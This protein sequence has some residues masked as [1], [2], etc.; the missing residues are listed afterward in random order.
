MR[1]TVFYTSL[2]D[3]CGT[4]LLANRAITEDEAS[5]FAPRME[6][7]KAS[8][9]EHFLLFETLA[10]KVYGENLCVPLLL[11]LF[12]ERGFRELL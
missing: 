9:F 6:A 12:G 11:R 5:Q 7:E 1:Q 2:N 3:F 10:L 4:Y 8:I